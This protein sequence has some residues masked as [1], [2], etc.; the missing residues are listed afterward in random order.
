MADKKKLVSTASNPALA[1]PV[2]IQSRFGNQG[3]FELVVP[4]TNG[5]F[6][7][8]WRDNDNENLPWQGPILVAQEVGKIDAMTMIQSNFGH[9]GNLEVIARIGEKLAFFWRDCEVEPQWHGPFFFDAMPACGNP[10]LIQSRF[11]NQG[12]FELVVPVVDGGFAFYWRDNDDENLPWQGP[13]LVAKEVGQIDAMTMIQS[14]FGHVGNLEV[15][16]RIGEKLAFFWRDCEVEPQW[17]GP[18]FFDAMPACGNPVLIQSRFG[19]QGNFELVVPVVDGGFAFYWRDNDD[20]NLPWQGPV[21]VA[22]EV[23]QIDAMTMIQSNF[24]H[25]GN[26]EVIARIGE[27]LAFFWRDCEVEPQWH[28]PF[29]IDAV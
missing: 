28:G 4:A 21:L 10:V 18:F 12:N 2:L 26:L 13:V 25:V 11:G 22:K 5:G 17:H 1:N 7:F 14:N 6:A 19:N 23:G 29:W 8:Y 3:N 24:G 16:A 27:K 20:E 9:V 15:I